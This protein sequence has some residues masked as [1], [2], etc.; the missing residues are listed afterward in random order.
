MQPIPPK[1]AAL[2]LPMSEAFNFIPQGC[3]DHAQTLSPAARA[4]FV[5]VAN[6]HIAELAR[7]LPKPWEPG[8]KE[9]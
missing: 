8:T 6:R 7:E 5:E 2:G 4:A 3:A 9:E 1:N